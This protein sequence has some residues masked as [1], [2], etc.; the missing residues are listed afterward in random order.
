MLIRLFLIVFLHAIVILFLSIIHPKAEENELKRYK[1]DNS[2][3]V[4]VSTLMN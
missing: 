1:L 4:E 2:L 3:I